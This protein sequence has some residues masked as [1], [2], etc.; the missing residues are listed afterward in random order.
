MHSALRRWPL[1]AAALGLALSGPCAT[2][3]LADPAPSYRVLLGQSQATAP[4]LA[5]ARSD[6]SRAEGLAR[7]ASARPNP[8]VGLTVENF[9]GNGRYR[10][11]GGSEATASI[12]QTLELGG[13]RTARIAVGR[14]EVELAR[15]RGK[16]A[17]ADFAF[18][19]A[20]AYAQAEASERRVQLATDA[21]SLARED[22]R[23]A[24]ALVRAGK[25]ADLRSI[26]A[27]AGVQAA[28]AALEDARAGS[29]G[30]FGKLTALS[31]SERPFT[32]LPAG[33][34]AHA[35][36]ADVIVA[37]DSLSSPAYLAALAA[38]E[39]A[40]R[41]VR[42]EQSRRTP[43]VNASLGLRRLYGDNALAMVGGV[44]AP[45]PLFNRNSG[46]VAGARAELAGADARLNAARLDALAE[47][48]SATVRAAAAQTRIVAAR[49]GEVAADEAYRLT[50]VGYEAGKLS[51]IELNAARRALSDARAQTLA[52]RLDRLSAEAALAR[53]QG[54]TPFGDQ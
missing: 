23:I 15:A 8:T 18:D 33:L 21:L 6:I 41:R 43:D 22:A 51:L 28:V 48:R 42:V 14:A 34:L 2:S 49:E 26:Q 11:F 36:R 10:D 47:A 39:A 25:E 7:Q 1:S 12:E 53:L 13:K 40:A 19:L 46:A 50:R 20:D 9:A 35:D 4:R 38:R 24:G 37:P 5:E 30:A 31:G 27:R 17:Q 54:L 16:Q 44:S 52:A 29:A 45:L 32:T 3:A